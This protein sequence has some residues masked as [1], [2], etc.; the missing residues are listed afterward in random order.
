MADFFSNLLTRSGGPLQASGT[1]LQPRLP[2]LFEV[3]QGADDLPVP[4][5][6][7]IV[8]N[9]LVHGREA[10]SAESRED[11][12]LRQLEPPQRPTAP[13]LA[14]QP[15]VTPRAQP[16]ISV[17]S[18]PATPLNAIS[19]PRGDGKIASLGTSPMEPR[20]ATGSVRPQTKPAA[21]LMI[22]TRL[23][24][25][26]LNPPR[27]TRLTPPALKPIL[28]PQPVHSAPLNTASP[29]INAPPEATPERETVIQVR[30]GR[31]E[32]RAV[33]PPAVPQPPPTPREQP[34]MSLDDYLRQRED[35]R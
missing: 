21:S 8:R 2:S 20:P 30:I 24:S 19:G 29:K 16:E 34:K 27:E 3:T 33:T 32:V 10:I 23:A 35:K 22:E 1:I 15:T 25:N 14:V 11:N 31:I 7:A 6:D 26:D 9:V 4:Q 12:N 13:G 17:S 28:T 5:A 18:A